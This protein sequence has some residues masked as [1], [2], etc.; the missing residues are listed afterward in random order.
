MLGG[1]LKFFFSFG[2]P[3]MVRATLGGYLGHIFAT[4]DSTSINRALMTV[5]ECY[6]YDLQA[7]S[8]YV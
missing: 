5:P 2:Y 3:V 6:I 7:S 8:T 4:R 1:L